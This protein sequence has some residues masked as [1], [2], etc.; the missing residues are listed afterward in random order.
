MLK[1]DVTEVLHRPLCQELLA[2]DVTRLAYVA[3][4]GTPRNIPIIFPR[5]PSPATSPTWRGCWST[6]ARRT[7][8]ASPT[9]G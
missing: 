9:A 2:R 4:D 8:T 1:N 7:C 6:W 3:K 5:S